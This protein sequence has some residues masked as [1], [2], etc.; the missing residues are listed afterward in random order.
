VSLFFGPVQDRPK[1]ACPGAPINLTVS[2]PP[3]GAAASLRQILLDI[4]LHS[5]MIKGIFSLKKANHSKEWDAK[6]LA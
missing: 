5:V 1:N 6:P 2:N 4:L 3:I